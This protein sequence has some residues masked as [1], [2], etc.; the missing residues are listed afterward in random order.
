MNVLVTGATGFV[1][2]AVVRALLRRGCAV[3]GLVRE[4]ARGRSLEELGASAAV[5]DMERP[6]T[7]EPLVSRVDAVVHAAQA[8]P[9]GRWSHRRIAAMHHSD[10]LMT[11]ALARACLAQGKVLV[12]TS[13]A[14]AHAGGREEWISE[15]TPLRPCLLAKGHADMVAELTC[16]H[17]GCGLRAL[18]ITPGFVYGA[19]G[20]LRET[21]ELLLRGRYRVIGSGANYWGLVHVEDLAEVYALALERGSPG[22]NYFVCDDVPMRRREVIDCV[23]DALGLPQAGK[24]PGWVVGLWLGFPLVEAINASL[25]MRND[26]V[27]QRL[28]WSPRY[29]SFADGLLSLL[30]QLR[31]QTSRMP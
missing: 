17:R 7:Y 24:V 9:Q 21:V 13:G 30:G 20:F 1:G 4:A 26:L 22:D 3:V 16:L 29:R 5:G 28:G 8:K 10:A 27:K 15:A 14:M 18:V 31:V 2:S 25:R 12:Y 6:E 23:T 11:R 19:G